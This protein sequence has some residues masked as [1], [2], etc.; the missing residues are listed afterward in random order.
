MSNFRLF[1]C[2]TIFIV[3]FSFFLL[4]YLNLFTS[5]LND[6]HVESR[7][8][9]TVIPNTSVNVLSGL[10]IFTGSD[11]LRDYI[12]QQFRDHYFRAR[13][14]QAEFAEFINGISID[15]DN[16]LDGYVSCYRQIPLDFAE[17]AATDLESLMRCFSD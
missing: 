6:L 8:Y 15:L 1:S 13:N 17:E 2:V 16:L 9:S 11:N 14:W 4:S 10:D 12:N 3:I 5:I 7:F